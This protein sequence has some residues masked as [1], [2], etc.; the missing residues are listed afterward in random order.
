MN[1][2][3]KFEWL[4]GDPD[5]ELKY[6]LKLIKKYFERPGKIRTDVTG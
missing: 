2:N 1:K 3:I 5:K 6:V 4:Q